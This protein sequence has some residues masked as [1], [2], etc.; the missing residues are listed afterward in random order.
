MTLSLAGRGRIEMRRLRG[1]LANEW[2]KLW[3]VRAT[4]ATLVALPVVSLVFSWMFSD[5]GGRSY[6][7]L[8]PAERLAFDPV[9]ISLQSHLMAQMVVGILGVLSVTTEYGTGMIANTAIAV[10]RRGV[11]L[12]AKTLVTFL[13]TLAAGTATAISSFILGQVVLGGHGAPTALLTDPLVVRAVVGMGVYLAI[14]SVLG[15]AV[16]V[17][18]RSSA[19]ALGII[20]AAMLVF[21]ALSQ[22]LPAT[23]AVFIARFWP[24]VAGS[25]IM[26]IVPDPATLAPWTGFALFAATVAMTTMTA[27]LVFRRRDISS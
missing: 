17:L 5:G 2:R 19:G 4:A 6:G 22:N 12:L 21:P 10:P 13:V 16:G 11:L 23:A 3:S 27:F 25:R 1:A 14:T 8:S 24:S 26:T 18:T 9:A 20:V 7:S 15:L